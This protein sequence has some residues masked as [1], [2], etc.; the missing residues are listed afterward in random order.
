MSLSPA[1]TQAK[2]RGAHT[3]RQAISSRERVAGWA[4]AAIL[5]VAFA[6]HVYW[7]LGGK[8]AAAAAYGSKDLPSSGVVALV[9]ALIGAAV[10][11]VLARIGTL[12]VSLPAPLLRWG[13]WALV[14]VFALAGLGNLAAP[15]DSYARE[16]HIAFFGPLLLIVAVLCTLVARSPLPDGGQR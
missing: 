11:F 4:V 12:S 3:S 16:W 15:A 6:V 10:A 8:W 1:A 14:A 2:R 13:A 9:A 7:A 5:A